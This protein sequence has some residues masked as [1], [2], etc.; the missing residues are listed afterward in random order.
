MHILALLLSKQRE[1]PCL[2]HT[3]GFRTLGLSSYPLQ[4]A[5]HTNLLLSK[6]EGDWS[7]CG[8]DDDDGDGDDGD[9]VI[10]VKSPG[11]SGTQPP[12]YTK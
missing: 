11:F 1:G 8:D 5:S 6:L 12:I 7:G 3:T 2:I 10:Q 4:R 9:A